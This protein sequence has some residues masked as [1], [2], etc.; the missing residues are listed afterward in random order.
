MDG[1]NDSSSMEVTHLDLNA[2]T[3]ERELNWFAEVIK[4]RLNL[5]FGEPCEWEDVFQIPAPNV[6]DD[7]S[8]Y[9]SLVRHYQMSPAERLVLVLALI[10]HVR[11]Q[12]LDL[13]YLENTATKRGY[14]EFGG[15]A[16]KFHSGFIPTGETAAFL[17]SGNDI[18]LRF[19]VF[20]LFKEDHFFHRHSILKLE[21]AHDGADEP[22]L[23]SPITIS[24]EY[25][26]Y[27]TTGDN[28]KPDYTTNFPA[29][30]IHTPLDW[31]NLVLDHHV[32][33]EVD[34]IITWI[35][36]GHEIMEEWGLDKK[37]K[38]GYRAMFYGPPGTGKTLTACLM[39]K[40]LGL[41]VYRI[42][43]SM[44]VS[45][46]IGETE[47]NLSNVFDQAEHK[48]W[49]LFF[50]EADALF[51]KRTQTSSSND[52]HANQEIAYLLQRIE[53]FP[54]VIILA[55]NLKGNLDDAFARR[56]QS[57]IYFPTPNEEERIQLWKNAF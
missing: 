1:R 49:I 47:K 32:R 31:E 46:Y 39:G 57:M 7:Q 33:E 9:A 53:D 42:D 12:A 11:P 37:V 52:R 3:L 29:K 13:F 27:L 10:P 8:L 23:S 44:V 15:L 22:V 48:N 45:K 20:Y 51:G 25:L 2:I 26:S 16:G 14:T 40:S 36:H 34:D 19:S 56:F 43:L 24:Q 18:Q 41:D 5:Y 30:L 38:R 4:T 54:G 6:E 55:S 17:L 28:Y 21:R 35:Q 50:D